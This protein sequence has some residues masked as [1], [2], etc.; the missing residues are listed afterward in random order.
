MEKDV[1]NAT[2]FSQVDNGKLLDKNKLM[3]GPKLDKD[4]KLKIADLGNSCW[5]FH[6]FAT[7]IQTCQYR[8]PEVSD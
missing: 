5:T 2:L 4:F 6:H 7:E 8:A 1:K 3:R